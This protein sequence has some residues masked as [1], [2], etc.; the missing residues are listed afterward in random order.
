MGTWGTGAFEN[1]MAMD[2]VADLEATEGPGLLARAFEDVLN[3]DGHQDAD[4]CQSAI[5]AA[6][7][8]AAFWGKAT[9]ALPGSVSTWVSRQV[10]RPDGDMRERAIAA[11]SQVEADSELRELWDESKDPAPW[12]AGLRDLKDR[13]SA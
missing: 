5:A 9:P 8:L 1:D 6:E 2:W 7:V 13:L 10:A 4:N 11:V 12:L 3:D